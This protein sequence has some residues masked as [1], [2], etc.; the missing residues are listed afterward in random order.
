MTLPSPRHPSAMFAAINFNDSE[1]A[2][3]VGV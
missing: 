3:H 1:G 2:H